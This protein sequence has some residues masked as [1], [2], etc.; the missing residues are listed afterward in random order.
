VGDLISISDKIKRINKPKEKEPVDMRHVRVLLCAGDDGIA[1]MISDTIRSKYD[2][3]ITSL[4]L[5]G[6]EDLLEMAKDGSFDIFIL[7]LNNI[8]YHNY[9]TLDEQVREGAFHLVSY[10]HSTYK[11]PI[12]ALYGY[13]DDPAHQKKVKLAGADFVFNMPFKLEPFLEAFGECLKLS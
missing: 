11:Q 9:R 3:E 5:L 12:I 2:L 1:E 6:E 7:V 13:P 8:I 4:P 10:L